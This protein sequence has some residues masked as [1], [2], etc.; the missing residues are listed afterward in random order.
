MLYLKSFD[1]SVCHF[2]LV[3]CRYAT[4]SEVEWWKFFHLNF[5]GSSH[6]QITLHL[7]ECS[8]SPP[9]NQHFLI[10]SKFLADVLGFFSGVCCKSW[11]NLGCCSFISILRSAFWCSSIQSSLPD[12]WILAVVSY[13]FSA[14]N[15]SLSYVRFL[16][17]KYRTCNNFPI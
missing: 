4:I 11:I 13:T 3:W 9:A 10:N 16:K 1:S 6:L 2:H 8:L 7:L 17:R 14:L 15:M 12:A 5:Q